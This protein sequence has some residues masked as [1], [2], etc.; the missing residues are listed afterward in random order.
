MRCLNHEF[1]IKLPIEKFSETRQQYRPCSVKYANAFVDIANGHQAP[2][3]TGPNS[4]TVSRIPMYNDDN[5]SNTTAR[6]VSRNDHT[7][8]T[9][10]SPGC[11]LLES[12]FN[13]ARAH[14]SKNMDCASTIGENAPVASLNPQ[15]V[16]EPIPRWITF[17]K[18]QM[19]FVPKRYKSATL[20]GN[21]CK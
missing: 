14:F 16:L 15:L 20:Q 5:A 6:Q 3:C 7:F 9:L 8:Q 1:Q 10:L 11:M 2:Q 17:H 19:E 21:C 18:I 4:C 13:L 12:A